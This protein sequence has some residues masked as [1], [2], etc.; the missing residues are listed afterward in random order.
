MS[1]GNVILLACSFLLYRKAG[2]AMAAT[3]NKNWKIIKDLAASF[4][5]LFV[6]LILILCK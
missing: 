1:F 2:N 3:N 4:W 6:I 5:I